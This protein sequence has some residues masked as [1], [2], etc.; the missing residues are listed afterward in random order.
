[1]QMMCTHEYINISDLVSVT[2]VT[3]ECFLKFD[4]NLQFVVLIEKYS[5]LLVQNTDSN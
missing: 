4:L 5:P 1:M 2:N 3:T